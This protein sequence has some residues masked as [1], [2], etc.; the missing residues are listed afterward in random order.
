MN[1]IKNNPVMTEDIVIAEKI[2]GPDIGALK[3]KTTRRK[4]APVL[5]DYIKIPRE[6]I[7]AQQSVTL[8]LDVM[9]VN[10]AVFLTTFPRNLYYR[11]AQHVKSQTPD[12]YHQ[13]LGAIFRIYNLGGFR[14]TD[15]HCNNEFRPL[16][17]PLANDFQVNVNYANPQEHVPEA[18]RNNRVIKECIRSTY[19]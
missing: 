4:P 7:A 14:I 16:M 11:T 1:C 10:G 3:G 19:H 2:F 8:C 15:A 18:E 9:K 6:L 17:D 13:C 12:V 5:P